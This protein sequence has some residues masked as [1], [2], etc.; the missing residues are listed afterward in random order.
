MNY[1]SL[2]LDFSLALICISFERDQLSNILNTTINA[3]AA[4]S[5]KVGSN[6]VLSKSAAI[7][8]S[9]AMRRPLNI[10][11]TNSLT[12]T[13]RCSL[14]ILE[15]NNLIKL[16]NAIITIAATKIPTIISIIMTMYSTTR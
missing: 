9:S 16:A 8:K 1:F 2:V 10:L 11:V 5:S 7:K 4:V 12:Y 14:R 6:T 15:S 3:N 13:C